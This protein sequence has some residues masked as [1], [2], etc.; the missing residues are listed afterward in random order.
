MPSREVLAAFGASET[1]VALPGGRGKSWRSGSLVLKPIDTPLEALDWMDVTVRAASVGGMRLSLPVRSES[2]ALLV[3]GWT[4]FP[5]LEGSHPVG[6]WQL[7]AEVARLFASTLSPLPR[8]SFLGVPRTHAWAQADRMAWKEEALDAAPP[9]GD[10]LAALL[11]AWRPVSAR[12]T[13]IH[14]DI[15]GNVVV[16]PGLAPAVIDL[17]FYWRPVEYSVAILAVDAVC[18]EDAP[19][20]LLQTIDPHPDFDQFL[21]RAVLFRMGTDALLKVADTGRYREAAA[22][23]LERAGR[24]REAEA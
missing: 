22:F 21:V 12:D 11:E 10:S 19:L 24:R 8:P 9:F 16:A 23:I 6:D 15:T 20:A 7:R 2:G 17:T 4:A 14:G 1:P 5:F 18:F 3:D 13:L